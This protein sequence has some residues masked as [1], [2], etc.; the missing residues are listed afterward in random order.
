MDLKQNPGRYLN[1]SLINFGS[2]RQKAASGWDSSDYAVLKGNALVLKKLNEEIYGA[3]AAEIRDSCGTP[4]DS[5][6]LKQILQKYS[7]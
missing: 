6:R 2:K 5:I 7:K 1:V 3:L 4:C